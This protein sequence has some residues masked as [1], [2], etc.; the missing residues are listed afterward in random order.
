[1]RICVAIS[2]A[3]RTHSSKYIL[4]VSPVWLRAGHEIDVFTAEHHRFP[5][6]V[7][8]VKLPKSRILTEPL[9][10]VEATLAVNLARTVRR[11][12]VTVAQA[13]RFFTPDVCYQQF[14]YAYWSRVDGR[15][16][17]VQRLV[18]R[19]ERRNLRKARRIVAMSRL[20][21]REIERIHGIEPEKIDVVYSGVNLSEFSP[22]KPSAEP[23]FVFAGNPFRRKGLDALI[24]G[25]RYCKEGKLLIFGKSLPG[26][27][28]QRYLRLA[29]RLGVGER[30]VYMGFTEKLNEQ[31]SSANAFIFPT[32][33]DPFGLVVLEA[34]A[35]GLPVITSSPSYCGAAE[36]IK[37]GR[38]GLL[39]KNPRDERE[40]GE[41]INLILED[42][43][44]RKRLGR[45]ARKTAE[46]YTW[47]RTASGFLEVFESL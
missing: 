21:K 3:L 15:L 14:T 16:S 5:E 35:S 7:R 36:L 27:P 37:D 10:T 39:L 31:F 44:L 41:K 26:D 33:Y 20:V 28:V 24:R 45:N 29:K 34:M 42:R 4:E 22:G 32:L 11:Y 23:T 18:I 30:V 13:T 25:L 40:I 8:V 2:H 6:G 38:N 12:D 19:A 9:F 46:R 47:D 17:P 43:N 1:M